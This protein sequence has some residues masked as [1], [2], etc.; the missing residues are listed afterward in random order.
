MRVLQLIDTLHPG[1]AERMAVNLA[2]T[3]SELEIPHRLV[4][5]RKHGDLGKLVH[6][7]EGLT[8]L[9]KKK[10]LDWKAFN[11]LLKIIDEFKPEVVHAHGTSVYWGVGVKFFRPKIK[12]IWHDH[13]GISEEVIQNN[14]RKELKWLAP[15]IDFIITA[16]ESTRDYW[17]NL[18]LK[19]ADK[20]TY[21]PNFP[22]LKPKEKVPTAIFTFIHLANYR[23]EKGH[24]NLLKA[25]ELLQKEAFA[26]KIRMVG[27]DIDKRWKEQI[28]ALCAEKNLEGVIS[29]EGAVSDVEDL[30]S[31]VDAGIVASEREGLPVALLEYG[32][33]ALPVVSTKVGQC[34][35]VLENGKFGIL[36]PA[37]DSKAMAEGM[38]KLLEAKE[39]A[40]QSGKEFRQHV[41]THYG[42]VQFMKHYQ[43]VYSNLVYHSNAGD[44]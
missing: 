43:K 18:G 22:Y 12:L 13:L 24:I 19:K 20:I 5:S 40:I 27:M 25:A 4:V 28:V 34:T 11:K 32:L 37:N 10:T 21:I 17:V 1:G 39:D 38:K 33:A 9:E 35:E 8:I 31:K 29:I 15:K 41:F 6:F 26:F 23:A 30:L 44:N 2:N 3:F 14:P 36:V 42:A 7:Q 16:N